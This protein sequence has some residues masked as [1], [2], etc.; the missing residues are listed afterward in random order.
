MAQGME[1]QTGDTDRESEGEQEHHSSTAVG[2]SWKTK[3]CLLSLAEVPIFP[4]RQF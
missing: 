1:S 3:H 4:Y 2:A